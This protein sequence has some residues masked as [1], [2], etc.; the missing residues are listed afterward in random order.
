MAVMRVGCHER[1]YRPTTAAAC[2]S[3]T[4]M[5]LTFF[6]V[7]A[8]TA[9]TVAPCRPGECAAFAV[10]DWVRPTRPSDTLTSTAVSPAMR[11]DARPVEHEVQI[12]S[13]QCR[14]VATLDF[15][16]AFEGHAHAVFTVFKLLQRL[17]QSVVRSGRHRRGGPHSVR[18]MDQLMPR[19][20]LWMW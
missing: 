10:G 2:S 3:R 9:G 14:T 13:Y 15:D 7:Q 17:A 20:R 4:I 18:A 5:P 16:D 1:L 6:A 12:F 11:K 19:E 8:V